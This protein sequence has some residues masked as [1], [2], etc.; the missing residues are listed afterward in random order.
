MTQ[1][2]SFD[3][4]KDINPIHYV[5]VHQKTH[6]PYLFFFRPALGDSLFGKFHSLFHDLQSIDH[7]LVG[8]LSAYS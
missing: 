4:P 3:L 8:Y 1:E 2:S 6:A 5:F 7:I